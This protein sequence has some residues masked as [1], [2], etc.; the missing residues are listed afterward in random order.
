MSGSA[1]LGL[2]V[3]VP[4]CGK[5]CPY[6]DFYSLPYRRA[7]VGEYLGA[8][9]AEIAGWEGRE[10]TADTLYFGGGTPS[11][12]SP[13]AVGSLIGAVRKAFRLPEVA[14]ITMEANPNT[15]TPARLAG[16]RAAGINRI[17]FGIQSA[18]PAELSALG[19][20]HSP[21]Q[22]ANAVC[23]A[24][25]AGIENI[26]ADLMLGTPR[27]T[28][29]SVRRSI[30]FLA[31]LPLQHISAYLLKPEEGTPYWTSP[32]LAECAQ[33]DALADI[34]HTAAD[35]LEAAGFRQYEISNFARPGFESAHNLKYWRC[36]DYL[37]F[38]PAAHS[39]FRGARFCHPA[40][41]AAYCRGG[42]KTP[43]VTD[44]A[45][46]GL[47]ERVMLGLRLVEGIPLGW[48]EEL[49]ERERAGF[50]RY[51]R[52]LT[53]A[54]LAREEE[55]RLALTREGFLVSNSILAD[56]LQFVTI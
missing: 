36:E 18:D 39:C 55:G 41:L 51:A 48:L 50:L 37:G 20:A 38:G 11:L 4:F 19:R 31:E 35:A 10:L 43:Q 23:A 15:V 49:P 33:E 26:S 14:E 27:Q 6:C 17:S 40:D 12:L 8:L 3:H 30:G 54:G 16:Y 29:D 34:Y 25:D 45:A 22:A 28:A 5:K 52:Q 44:D 2:Y 1:P 13:D 21:E 32:L 47:D 53:A 46:G 9:S 7:A 42:W 24:R 56:L